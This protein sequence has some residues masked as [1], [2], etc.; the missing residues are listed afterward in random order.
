MDH[1]IEPHGGTLVSLIV[2]G[3]RS[4][5]IRELSREWPSIDLSQRQLWTSS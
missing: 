3:E 4:D 2:G 5:E 1:L